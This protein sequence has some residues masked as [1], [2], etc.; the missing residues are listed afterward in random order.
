MA[1]AR[2]SAYDEEGTHEGNRV[3]EGD[4]ES[5][6]Q[7]LGLAP[8]RARYS[9]Q[10]GPAAAWLC[11][12][13]DD[14]LLVFD[15]QGVGPVVAS[16]KKG[17]LVV[18][19]R[20][21][22]TAIGTA[23]Y[24]WSLPVRTKA[25]VERW[26]ALARLRSE[27]RWRWD[28]DQGGRYVARA[29]GLRR[30]ALESVLQGGETLLGW[31]PT[32]R[33]LVVP[34]ACTSHAAVKAW[35]L[36][37]DQRQALVALGSWGTLCVTPVAFGKQGLARSDPSERC[38]P[39]DADR[40]G[41]RL[42]ELSTLPPAPPASRRL[43]A[44]ALLL[45]HSGAVQ[46]HRRAS[47]WVRELVAAGD[48][49]ATLVA[50][51][52][53]DRELYPAAGGGPALAGAL[54]AYSTA[55]TGAELLHWWRV[56]GRSLG[57]AAKLLEECCS[58]ERLRLW[59]VPFH[60]AVRAERVQVAQDDTAAMLADCA[61]ADDLL[62]AG[63]PEEA[64]VVL[65]ARHATLFSLDS[66]FSLDDAP[67]VEWAARIELLALRVR[68]H[69]AAA[70]FDLAALR[71]LAMADPTRPDVLR[72]LSARSPEPE[73]DFIGEALAVLAPGG[74]KP[75]DDALPASPYGD[76]SP[77][78]EEHVEGH[79][80]FRSG[81]SSSAMTRVQ[82]LLARPSGP[83][84]ETLRAYCES[85][86]AKHGAAWSAFLDAC[87]ALSVEGVRGFVSRGERGVGV[88]AWQG[89]P[90]VL[91][92]GG[93]HLEARGELYLHPW[94]LRFA[95]AR[96]VCHLR[97]GDTRF[98]SADVWSGALDTGRL[99]A[100]LLLGMVPLFKGIELIDR[101]GRLI[102]HYRGSPLGRAIRG[103]ELAESTL[104]RA[105][106]R[107]GASVSVPKPKSLVDGPLC[108]TPTQQRAQL[109]ADRAGLLLAGDLA[110]ALRAMCITARD[111]EP[112]ITFAEE[113][114]LT[115]MVDVYRFADDPAKRQLAWRITALL[116]FALT[117]SYGLLR[118]A[119]ES[120]GTRSSNDGMQ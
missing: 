113:R 99:G 32:R 74:M 114:G 69:E 14:C 80:C 7:R 29:K 48:A 16:A 59:A 9:L 117:E 91:V 50:A 108:V 52:L 93:H 57:G 96:E 67:G 71:E 23:Q 109:T 15:E 102:E 77:W 95:V 13:D 11:Q 97:F 39:V 84:P 25:R 72:A 18:D 24:R 17:T 34:G 3:G 21:L 111:G 115:E 110:A 55:H 31:L 89:A 46:D 19:E 42:L 82:E 26:Y 5:L 6:R 101:L 75:L 94:E 68:A 88:R 86:G 40:P 70:R 8:V 20:P 87:A 60:A 1:D 35:L 120:A 106:K 83:A 56:T 73:R 98:A 28:D 107:G 54:H 64:A 118:T 47:A 49:T 58:D 76:V 2:A 119:L 62:H 10:K 66:P 4:F 61:F 41:A 37:T 92:I 12:T 27:S 30:A 36:V 103:I 116:R 44:A 105:R 45:R 63:R 79:L 51:L 65:D 33:A 100:E 85:L 38:F 53:G 81:R 104:R 90:S 78:P 43:H 22:A 112:T